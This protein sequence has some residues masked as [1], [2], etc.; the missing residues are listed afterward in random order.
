MRTWFSS[1]MNCGQS[2]YWPGGQD[3][4]DRAAPAVGGQVDLGAQAA[5]GP[6]QRLPGRPRREILVIWRCPRD[7]LRGQLVPGSGGVL[8]RADHG[9]IGA[10]GPVLPLGLVAPGPQPAQDLL[11][12][13]VQ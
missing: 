3:A 6:A 8:V 11:P 10:E 7:Q 2:P 12:G 9:G 1:G 5:A 13:P 4:G